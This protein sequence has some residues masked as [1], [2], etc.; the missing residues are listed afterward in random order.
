MSGIDVTTAGM[1]DP[2]LRRGP[3]IP[4]GSNATGAI[5]YRGPQIKSESLMSMAVMRQQHFATAAQMEAERSTW[6]AW[7]QEVAQFILPERGR[8][9]VTDVNK[10]QNRQQAI[11][12]SKASRCLRTLDAGMMTGMTSPARP[13]FTYTTEDPKLNEDPR[14]RKCM[15]EATETVRRLFGNSNLYNKLPTVFQDLGGFGTSA[16][17]MV[18]HPTQVFRFS[19]FPVGSYSLATNQDGD[20]DQFV[21]KAWFTA[22]Q[23]VERF[24]YDNCSQRTRQQFDEQ[25]AFYGVEAWWCIMPNPNWDGMRD[26]AQYKKYISCWWEIGATDG[27]PLSCSGH[28]VFPILCPRWEVTG[29]DV[30]GTCPGRLALPEVKELMSW[31]KKIARARDKVVDPALQVP[32]R[33]RMQS[34]GLNPGD[35]TVVDSASEQIRPVHDLRFDFGMMENIINRIENAISECTF[36]SLFMAI[37]NDER[38]QPATAREIIERHEEKLTA[39]GPVLNQ[40]NTDLLKPLVERAYVMAWEAGKF[41]HIDWP[42]TT[43]ARGNVTRM[44]AGVRVKAEFVSILQQA[45]RLTE[46]ASIEKVV[47]FTSSIVQATQDP[48]AFDNLNVDKMV[49]DYADLVGALE[50]D[51]ASADELKAKRMHRA[52]AQAAQAKQAQAAAAAVNAKNLAAAK[53]S[54]PSALTAMT[55]GGDVPGQIPWSQ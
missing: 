51:L 47:Q 29:E 24:G 49:T 44:G 34:V 30:Y 52:Q 14:M 53:T 10:G 39:L 37:S 31:I 26:G 40:V 12:N 5:G 11:R 4:R 17:S 41:N 38:Q 18:K 1:D 33:L 42:T 35:I 23:L 45:Q 21:R 2:P 43:D 46:V 32:A 48:S 55:T 36:E 19:V 50:K 54:D 8:F 9:F 22:R 28:D 16:M 15:D 6:F 7:W 20:V 3:I 13:W 27:R 25:N